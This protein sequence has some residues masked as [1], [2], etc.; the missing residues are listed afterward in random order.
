MAGLALRTTAGTTTLRADM[1]ALF[2]FGV[3]CKCFEEPGK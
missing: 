2:V 3:Q 1:A